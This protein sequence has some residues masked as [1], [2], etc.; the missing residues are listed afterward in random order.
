MKNVKFIFFCITLCLTSIDY[1][2]SGN[3]P[4][5]T[6]PKEGDIITINVGNSIYAGHQGTHVNDQTNY[7]ADRHDLIYL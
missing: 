2:T 6:F 7:F 4:W 5:V 1:A 3:Y